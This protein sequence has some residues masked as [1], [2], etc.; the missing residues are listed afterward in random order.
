MSGILGAVSGSMAGLSES[1]R[2]SNLFSILSKV[3]YLQL[4]VL[5]SENLSLPSEVTKY[6]I[7]DGSEIS[8]HI[9]Q[10]SE[11]LSI[12]GLITA[13]NS[14]GFTFDGFCKSKLIDAVDTLRRMHKERQIVKVITGMGTYED[15]G[16]TALSFNRQSGDPGGNWLDINVTLRKIKKVK[17]KEADLPAEEKTPAGSSAKGKTGGTENKG[18]D[19]GSGSKDPKDRT[20][21]AKDL[22]DAGAK[23]WNYL[24][25]IGKPPGTP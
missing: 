7:E 10:G 1:G 5:V 18:G 16:F 15:M 25:N 23:G 17:L 21:L 9:T 20:S 6:P 12:T 19:K 14:F 11:E 13:S 3:G 2:A 22:K 24:S 8:D 4:D